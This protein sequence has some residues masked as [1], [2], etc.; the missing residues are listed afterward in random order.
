M[1]EDDR[2]RLV[3]GTPLPCL[4]SV[5]PG[6]MTAREGYP[7][8]C[9]LHG[10]CEA[11][12]AETRRALTL[13]GPLR[14]GNRCAA[15]R[16]F[17]L[18]A[19]QLPSPESRWRDFAGP[20]LDL[21]AGIRAR[22]CGKGQRSYLTGFSLGADAVF[23]IAKAAP[24]TFAALWAVDP[25]QVPDH[26]LGIP[27]WLSLG[28]LSRANEAGFIKRLRLARRMPGEQRARV[29]EDRGLDHVGT[30]TA[31]YRDNA[32]YEWLL[33]KKPG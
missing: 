25:T 18:A 12:P 7:L 33:D 1:T 27:V 19:P 23:D 14:P 28:E 29:Y 32:I 24:A 26:D 10:L 21:L 22:F 31:A 3:N 11:A 8:L 6:A 16:S 17:V 4:V 15:I 5:P 2:I 13:H 9:F 20:V 30:A